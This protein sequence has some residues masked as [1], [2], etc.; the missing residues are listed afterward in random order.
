MAGDQGDSDWDKVKVEGDEATL[1]S[2]L[3]LSMIIRLQ[4]AQKAHG[5]TQDDMLFLVQKWIQLSMHFQ[6]GGEAD[7][8]RV[9]V[10]KDARKQALAFANSRGGLLSD[11]KGDPKAQIIVQSLDD[12]K[13]PPKPS[14]AFFKSLN[15]LANFVFSEHENQRMM[16]FNDAEGAFAVLYYNYR[17]KLAA[18][19]SAESNFRNSIARLKNAHSIH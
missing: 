15:N 1:A 2:Q 14:V 6:R 7:R 17:T 8:L 16:A 3:I 18:D 19:R 12:S 9:G 11:F 4:G 5:V 10:V 13:N